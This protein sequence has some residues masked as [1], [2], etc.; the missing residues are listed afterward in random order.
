MDQEKQDLLLAS[1]KPEKRSRIRKPFRGRQQ[2]GTQNSTFSKPATVQNNEA[3]IT[4]ASTNSH[5]QTSNFR[6]R[7]REHRGERVP[8]PI[9][10]PEPEIQG[11]QKGLKRFG[12]FG[13]ESAAQISADGSAA[14][15][16]T[17]AAQQAEDQP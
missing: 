9:Q 1:K 16:I 13:K 4:P 11:V 14:I 5:S 10:G 7:G 15:N 6:E 17:P 3:A 2:A 12:R 8:N